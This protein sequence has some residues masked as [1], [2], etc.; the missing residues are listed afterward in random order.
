MV[1]Q[2]KSLLNLVY[3]VFYRARM[4]ICMYMYVMRVYVYITDGYEW[5][6]YYKTA[7]LLTFSQVAQISF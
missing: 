3:G 4:F 2:H 1:F 6:T 7:N 5:A